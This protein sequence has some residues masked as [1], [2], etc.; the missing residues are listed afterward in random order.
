MVPPKTFAFHSVTLK[1]NTQDKMRFLTIDR[2][3]QVN[4]EN[5]RCRGSWGGK[6]LTARDL[7]IFL[8]FSL[9]ENLP[10]AYGDNETV[11]TELIFAHLI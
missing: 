1:L 6:C 4:S 2:L 8:Q 10:F 9:N 3:M 5:W 7:T 11:V